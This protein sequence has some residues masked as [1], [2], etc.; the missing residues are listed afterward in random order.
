M[1]TVKYLHA[2]LVAAKGSIALIGSIAGFLPFPWMSVYNCTKAAL[3]QWGQTLRIEMAPFGYV[4]MD[5]CVGKCSK[6][7]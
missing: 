7:G 2:H 4:E 1:R 5:L 6:Q 3:H